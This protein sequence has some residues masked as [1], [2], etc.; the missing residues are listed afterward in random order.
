M[1]RTD[2]SSSVSPLRLRTERSLAPRRWP[3]RNSSGTAWPVR[4]GKNDYDTKNDYVKLTVLSFHG[5]IPRQSGY[6]HPHER[7][8]PGAAVFAR[9]DRTE[10]RGPGT[11]RRALGGGGDATGAAAAGEPSPAL[12]CT[13]PRVA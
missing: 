7:R 2:S 6:A 5:Q 9:A 8:D 10:A 4:T 3:L 12:Q 1:Q 13:A 11:E